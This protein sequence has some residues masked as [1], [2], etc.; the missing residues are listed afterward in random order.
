MTLVRHWSASALMIVSMA[1]ATQAQQPAA[2]GQAPAAARQGGPRE[3]PQPI[4]LFLRETWKETPGNVAVTQ[5]HVLSKGVDLK[6]Y[7]KE[8]NITA[9]GN[10]PH[11]W[12]G[13][14]APACAVAFRDKDRYVDLTGKARMKW[15][16]KTSGFHEVRPVV[17]LADGTWLVGTFAD[18]HT[19]EFHESEFYFGDLRWLRL[20]MPT[21]ATKGTLLNTADLGKVD[22]VGFV[23]LTQGSGHGLGGFSDVGWI[24]VYG[25]PVPR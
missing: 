1:V 16:V 13:L 2:G 25:K 22:E 23:D 9:E 7:G 14:C 19:F 15:L 11:I 24:E 3:A 4:P 21:L 8:V 5:D 12:T 10:V 18:A 20:D 17:K 6:A